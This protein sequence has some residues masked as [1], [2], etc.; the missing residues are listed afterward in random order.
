MEG[1]FVGCA[2]AE[3]GYGHSAAA[4]QLG[5]Q[6]R[7]RG[8]GKSGS[9]DAVGAQHSHAKVG[10]V[11]GAALAMAVTVAASEQF[12]HHE[13]DVRA[14][15][16]GVAVAP[17]GAGDAIFPAQGRTNPHRHRFLPDVG[18][19]RPRD[20][21]GVKLIGGPPVKGADGHHRPVHV[22]QLIRF[23]S[24]GFSPHTA[25]DQVVVGGFYSTVFRTATKS[26]E[27]KEWERT[28]RHP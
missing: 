11:H 18:V 3:E 28:W 2:V 20:V 25:W 15:G 16:D 27:V 6:G 14:F 12:G 1:P 13:L 5:R 26:V 9:H 10:D 22:Q 8:Q 24:H 21:S 17:V 7:A 19:D 23:Q 4:F